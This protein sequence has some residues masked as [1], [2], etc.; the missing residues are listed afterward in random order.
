[1]TVGDLPG[2]FASCID[3]KRNLPRME[4]LTI[5]T[6]SAATEYVGRWNRLISTTNWEKGRIICQWREALRQAGA[7]LEEQTDEAWSRQ[8]GGVTPQHVGRLRRVFERFGDAHEQFAG[9]YWSHFLAAIEWPDAEM[10]LE[11]A[12][13]NSWSISQ[14][15]DNRWEAIGG[16]PEQ[17]PQESDFAADEIDNDFSSYEGQ[18]ASS[19]ISESIGEVRDADSSEDESDAPPFD[20][21]DR[22]AAGDYTP[23]VDGPAAVPQ[24]RPFESLPPLPS[25]MN[26]AF[27]M[28]KLAILGHKVAGWQDIARDDVL[29]MLE[30]LKQLVLA[31]AE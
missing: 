9:L 11:G 21:G 17:K 3:I 23:V 28:M 14:M 12:V 31:P 8:V 5:S 27:E 30:S 29:S 18:T 22:E 2:T 10:Y 15:C 7:P 1:M 16:K 20:V 25:D 24:I 26:E 6:V 13:Q 19:T 4:E